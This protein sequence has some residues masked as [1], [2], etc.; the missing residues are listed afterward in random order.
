MYM[1]NGEEEIMDSDLKT[2]CTVELEPMSQK[3]PSSCENL[4]TGGSQVTKPNR[5]KI[6]KV[7]H[8]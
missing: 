3:K 7:T 8:E 1:K 4:L 6:F 5:I 2:L